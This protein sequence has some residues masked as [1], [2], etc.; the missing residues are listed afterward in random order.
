[1]IV[2]LGAPATKLLLKTRVGITRLRGEWHDFFGVPV[3]P[4]FH[5]AYL[6]R[7]YTKEN[8]L[9]VWEDL[10]AAKARIDE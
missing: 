7:A 9:K 6:L 3:M 2:T 8:R 1:M 5:P 10:K 4:T